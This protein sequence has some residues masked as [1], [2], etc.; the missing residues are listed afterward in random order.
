M[1]ELITGL[2][3]IKEIAEGNEMENDRFQSFIKQQDKEQTDRIVHQINKWVSDK[4]DCTQCG[5]CC[6]SLMINITVEEAEMLALKKGISLITIKEKYVE[7]SLGGQLIINTIPCH[8]LEENRCTIYA[9]RFTE[10]RDFPHLHKPN[11]AG[12]LFSTMMYYSMCPIIFN[13]VEELKIKLGFKIVAN[14]SVQNA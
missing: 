4:I 6:R 8:F 2:S 7:E 3:N 1:T 12:R 14:A 5:N 13:V 9:D 10:C 11:F